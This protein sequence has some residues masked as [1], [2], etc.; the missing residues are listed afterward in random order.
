MASVIFRDDS[1]RDILLEIFECLDMQQLCEVACLDR[2]MRR[3]SNTE[4]L[5]ESHW[6]ELMKDKWHVFRFPGPTKLA[7]AHVKKQSSRAWLCPDELTNF[8]WEFRLKKSA[9]ADWLR[10]DPHARGEKAARVKFYVDGDVKFFGLPGM[11]EK[12]ISWTWAGTSCGRKGPKG[13]FLKL[14]VGGAPLPAYIVTRHANWGFVL[15]NCWG[16]LTSFPMPAKGADP[17][18]EDEFLLNLGLAQ[19]NEALKYREWDGLV[20]MIRRATG[21]CTGS[22]QG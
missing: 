10:V 11:D 16:I 5:W 8:A 18:L 14:I 2:V 3:L 22:H 6:G 4:Q 15:Q 9:G 13:S 21:G 20:S 17:A 19:Q 1:Q 12:K 7:L